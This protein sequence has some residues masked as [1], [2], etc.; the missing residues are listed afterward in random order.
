M[1]YRIIKDGEN[2]YHIERRIFMI[3]WDVDDNHPVHNSETLY[4]QRISSAEFYIKQLEYEQ[5][6]KSEIVKELEY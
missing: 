3:W 4:F 1:K 5:N 2:K 6:R